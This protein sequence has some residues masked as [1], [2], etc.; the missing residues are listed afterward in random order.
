MSKLPTFIMPFEPMTIQ[1]LG[2][3]LYSTFPPVISEL[4]SNAYDAES[5][6]VEITLPEGGITPESKVII[7][8]YG[9]GLSASEIQNEYLPIGRD[10]R[11]AANK[12]AMSK[13]GKR[14]VTGRKGLGKLSSFGIA[15]EM[16]IRSFRNGNAICLLLNYDKMASWAESNLPNR[17]YEPEVI[18]ELTGPTNDKNGVEIV[19][20][21]LH[22]RKRI[23][24]EIVRKG[25]AKR[26]KL[27]GRGFKVFVNGS[28]IKPGDRIN[29]E[30]C[31]EGFS[32]DVSELPHSGCLGDSFQV[33]GWIGFLIGSSQIERGIDIF[34]T[35]KAVELG[36]FFNYSSTNVQFARAHLVGEIHADFLDGEEDLAATARNSVIWDS[37][38]GQELRDWGHKTLKWAFQQWLALRRKEKEEKVIKA[39]GFDKWLTTRQPA[40]QRVAKKMVNL[41]VDD[42]NIE[43]E[44]AGPLLEIIKSSVETVAF[45]ELVET[46]EEFEDK[47]AGAL[48]KLFGEWR[49]IEAREHLKLA[50]GRQEAMEKLSKFI[51]TGAL[52]VQQ[53]QPLFDKNIWLIDPAWSESDKQVSYTKL[54]RQNCKEP[55]N[56]P[57][58]DRRIDILGIRNGGGLSVVE[59]KRPKKT[60]TRQDLEQ[61]EKYVDWAR[62][63][64]MGTG[65]DSPKY[66]NGLLIAGKI[67]PSH[68]RKM[69]RL[70]GDDIRVETYDDLNT[71]AQTVFGQVQREL[72]KIAPEYTRSKRKNRKIKKA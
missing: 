15:S 58:K 3:R 33:S 53:M 38:G 62:S 50:D 43:T 34:A 2:L 68:K 16:R 26:L 46:I 32:W 63:N 37:K 65:E 44:S 6:K 21:K 70:A 25:L 64:I 36:S 59:I 55:K 27:I 29:R 4:V 18:K 40:E 28:E 9:H 24:P 31:A 17:P 42:E 57:N 72:E 47:N 10:R 8:D 30:N 1:H 23:N 22:R 71:R 49:V 5:A 60:L 48:L 39:V 52:E 13:N 54:L 19:L 45:H 7:R 11:G 56:T 69:E 67:N 61:I 66:I 12:N 35:G 41:L 14:R 51:D 20:T